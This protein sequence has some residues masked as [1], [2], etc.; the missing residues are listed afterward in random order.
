MTLSLQN[1]PGWWDVFL[2]KVK[3]PHFLEWNFLGFYLHISPLVL[4]MGTTV[5]IYQNFIVMNRSSWDMFSMWNHSHFHCL[6]STKDAL[7]PLSPWWH[8]AEFFP[9]QSYV[10][11]TQK[12][13]TGLCSFSMSHK[14]WVEVK[15]H[16]VEF[17]EMIFLMQSTFLLSFFAIRALISSDFPLVRLDMRQQCALTSQKANHVL[18]WNKKTCGQNSLRTSQKKVQL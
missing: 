6:S 16:P 9:L 10:S 2:Q 1:S 14:G 5:C 7:I 3:K 8:L 15:D 11:G 13:R 12:L 17:L 4:W 18:V